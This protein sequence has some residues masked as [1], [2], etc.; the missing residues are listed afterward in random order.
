MKKRQRKAEAMVQIKGSK[1]A[2]THPMVNTENA[3]KDITVSI[4]KFGTQIQIWVG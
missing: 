4:D 2:W 3:P 1:E